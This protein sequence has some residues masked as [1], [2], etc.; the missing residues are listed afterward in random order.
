MSSGYSDRCRFAQR[1]QRPKTSSFANAPVLPFSSTSFRRPL[2]SHEEPGCRPSPYS[3]TIMSIGN[4]LRSAPFK[5]SPCDHIYLK[6]SNVFLC[7]VE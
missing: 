6:S 3:S 2:L 1:R 7:V 5:R 4:G